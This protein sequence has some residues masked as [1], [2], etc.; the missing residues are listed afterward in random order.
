MNNINSVDDIIHHFKVSQLD[1]SEM[2]NR[3]IYKDVIKDA[4][5]ESLFINNMNL[6]QY[7]EH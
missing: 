1:E 5:F 6:L 7:K 2:K 4:S 3:D